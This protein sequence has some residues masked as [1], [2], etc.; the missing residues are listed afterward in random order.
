MKAFSIPLVL[1]AVFL[2]I[3]G[4]SNKQENIQVKEQL[5]EQSP[6][7]FKPAFT[8][9]TVIK[10]NHIVSMQLKVI[11]EYDALAAP[12]NSNRNADKLIELAMRSKQNLENMVSAETQLIKSGEHYN[13]ATFAGMKDFV[14]DVERELT[15]IA[16]K[17]TKPTTP[18]TVAA[19][20][21]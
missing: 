20:N 21:G 12:K 2:G 18:S 16:S 1:I 15:T 17:L 3:N 4:C 19:V 9:T 8:K 14:Q 11:N 10:L 6:S 5:K 13:K 7:D